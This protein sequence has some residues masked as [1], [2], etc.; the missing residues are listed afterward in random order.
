MK[1]KL[2]K[3]LFVLVFALQTQTHTYAQKYREIDRQQFKDARIIS[4]VHVLNKDST[5]SYQ[6]LFVDLLKK[7]TIRN[8]IDSIQHVPCS[9][10]NGIFFINDLTGFLTECGGCYGY[11]NYLFRTTNR[12]LTWKKIAVG[13]EWVSNLNNK[14]FYMFNEQQG[15]IVWGINGDVFEYSITHDGGA[16]WERK[17]IKFENVFYRK[18]SSIDFS[19]DGQVTIVFNEPYLLESERK[20]TLVIQS[21]DYGK[22]F[23][24]MK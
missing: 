3:I 18:T 13:N 5:S 10:P 14:T 17:D 16:S 8:I 9:E 24:K 1:M 2:L 7:D 23:H 6:L 11:Y 20:R 4:L 22:S 12:G 21:N 15:I 19:S